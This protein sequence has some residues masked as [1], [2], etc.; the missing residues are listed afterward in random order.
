MEY[1][2][3]RW[4]RFLETVRAVG[5]VFLSLLCLGIFFA[6]VSNNNNPDRSFWTGA[7]G[8]ALIPTAITFFIGLMIIELTQMGI[9]YIISGVKPKDQDGFFIRNLRE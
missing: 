2:N 5:Y 9:I 8:D 4:F 1:N 3:T 7:R 6:L